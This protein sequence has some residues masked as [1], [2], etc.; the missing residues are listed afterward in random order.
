MTRSVSDVKIEA[1]TLTRARKPNEDEELASHHVHVENTYS[2]ATGSSN[3]WS[4]SVSSRCAVVIPVLQVSG[5][6]GCCSGRSKGDGPACVLPSRNE[7]THDGRHFK[8]CLDVLSSR[9]DIEFTPLR[10]SFSNNGT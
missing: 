8:N 4:T 3:A 2:Q 9:R 7:V 1:G 5:R 6:S 10:C